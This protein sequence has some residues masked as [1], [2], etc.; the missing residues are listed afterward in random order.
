M[1]QN[2]SRVSIQ[3]TILGANSALPFHGRFPSAQVLR[4]GNFKCLIDCG[5]GTQLRLSQENI[6][7]NKI[8]VVFIS[9]LHGDHVYGLPGLLT[10]YNH[11]E[12]REP[13]LIVGPKGV[14]D[15]ITQIFE[16]SRVHLN[17]EL[18]F[19]EISK[20]EAIP[21]VFSDGQ[22]SVRAFPLIHRLPTW[23]YRFDHNPALYNVRPESIEQYNL[24]IEEIV[25]VKNG[26]PVERSGS[27]V[28]HDH[29]AF[30]LPPSLSYAYC[31]DTIYTE[32]ILPYI[33]GVD[34][35]YHEA[36]YQEALVEKA[37][38]TK[39]ATAMEAARM[40]KL[41]DVKRLLLGHFSSRYKTLQG[42]LDE[43]RPIFPE[44]YIAE[45][46]TTWEIG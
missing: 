16:L 18:S 31:S 37:H 32:S 40:A 11:F 9:H 25:R 44:T 4:S 20:G 13:I 29:L 35:L 43:A 28:P 10:S 45:E 34:L 24:T 14:R 33:K 17:Y 42:H 22:L 41:A 7:R 30:P 3:V 15:M 8:Q 5:E 19:R 23:G 12:R 39:H 6:K 26:Q 2:R 36:T 38:E 1:S 27:T 46:G 21:T